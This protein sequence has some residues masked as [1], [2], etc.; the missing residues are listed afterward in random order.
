MARRTRVSTH[1]D[2]DAEFHRHACRV[3]HAIP[4]GL[5]RTV[6]ER[7][8]AEC[9]ECAGTLPGEEGGEQAPRTGGWGWNV[10][11]R[12]YTHRNLYCKQCSLGGWAG[13]RSATRLV[14]EALETPPHV[15]KWHLTLTLS[16]EATEPQKASVSDKVFRPGPGVS[17]RGSGEGPGGVFPLILLDRQMDGR[18]DGP[19]LSPLASA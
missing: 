14:L 17:R 18:T 19:A 10:R 15:L 12:T 3:L 2:V 6:P 11:G 13:G 4:K 5:P 16:G 7:P 1:G 8:A 9:P